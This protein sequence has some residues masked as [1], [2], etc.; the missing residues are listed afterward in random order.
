[1]S[2]TYFVHDGSNALGRKSVEEADVSDGLQFSFQ[3][4]WGT[5]VVGSPS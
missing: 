2:A 4:L 3:V 1:M 5:E